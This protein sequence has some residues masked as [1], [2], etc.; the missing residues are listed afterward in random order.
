MRLAEGQ[1]VALKPVITLRPRY[2]MRMVLTNRAAEDQTKYAAH[3]GTSGTSN[4]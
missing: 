1:R 4:T 3:V 2:G